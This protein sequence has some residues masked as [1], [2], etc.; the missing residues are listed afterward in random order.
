MASR[1]LPAA[2]SRSGGVRS[3]RTS[4]SACSNVAGETTGP[5]GGEVPNAGGAPGGN[6]EGLAVCP[7]RAAAA[8]SMPSD[9]RARNSL[10]DFAMSPPN[11]ALYPLGQNSGCYPI[12]DSPEKVSF[13]M[14]DRSPS[15]SQVSELNENFGDV[16]SEHAKRQRKLER[17]KQ[18]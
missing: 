6:S 2:I 4:F 16:L 12:K 9:V 14:S 8:P 17:A 10:R 5:T 13:F 11:G 7:F 15:E 1:Q 3:K 18:R